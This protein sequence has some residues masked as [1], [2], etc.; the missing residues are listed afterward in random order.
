MSIDA[1]G[2]RV[3]FRA[4]HGLR[5]LM[6][7]WIV[8]FHTNPHS[9]GRLKVTT[10]GWLAVDVFFIMSGYVLMQTHAG[11]FRA[12]HLAA[13]SRFLRMR[14]YRTYPLYLVCTMVAAAIY[15]LLMTGF[16]S[17]SQLAASLLLLEGWAL[18]GIGLNEAVWSLGV[19]WI[20]YLAFPL[21]CVL[22]WRYRDHSLL[23]LA[24]AVL[25]EIIAFLIWPV[26]A[27]SGPMSVVR[28]GGEF[29]AGCSLWM[30]HQHTDLPRM[31]RVG[32]YAMA[33]AVIGLVAV[34]MESRDWI[35]TLPFMVLMVHCAAAPG[36]LVQSLLGNRIALFLGRISFS[37]YL[38]H[39]LLIK[40]VHLL[41][42]QFPGRSPPGFTLAL[43][44]LMPAVALGLCVWVEEPTR[45]FG[46]RALAL[47]ATA[48]PA[49]S[50]R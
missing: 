24:G 39:T 19:E 34:L 6:A 1:G 26:S 16:P 14:W 43:Y 25:G 31:G 3:F 22:S 49:I 29:T 18:P 2:G 36:A 4:L 35:F 15:P 50:G 48:E 30:L 42:D 21:V 44:L 9:F 46:R 8:T 12:L 20:G 33:I 23:I 41:Q 11:E 27:A 5:G 37:L 32:D 40:L 7:V 10:Y 28:M 17:S 45:R 38:S 47:P 13:V